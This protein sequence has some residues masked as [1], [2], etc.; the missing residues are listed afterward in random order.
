MCIRDRLCNAESIFSEIDFAVQAVFDT[1]NIKHKLA[2][3]KDPNVVVAGEFELNRRRVFVIV[4]HA[5]GFRHG[6]RNC[7]VHAEI[8]IGRR[9]V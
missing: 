2:V 7:S 4:A 6:E 5:A 8:I 3:D 9:C 1:A